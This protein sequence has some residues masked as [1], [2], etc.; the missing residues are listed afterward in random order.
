MTETPTGVGELEFWSQS[1]NDRGDDLCVRRADE[2]WVE[3]DQEGE[4]RV[5]ER[6]ADLEADGVELF[7]GENVRI[8]FLAKVASMEAGTFLVDVRSDARDS[9]G[10]VRYFVCVGRAE[11][12]QESGWLTR[13]REALLDFGQDFDRPVAADL[14][15]LD[16]GLKEII[17]KKAMLIQTRIALAVGGAALLTGAAAMWWM[18]RA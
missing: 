11:G 6:I 5:T 18:S 7:S 12:V 8:L 10:R 1:L 3:L 14:D 15:E 13:V 2:G 4:Y 17:K 16:A 9:A